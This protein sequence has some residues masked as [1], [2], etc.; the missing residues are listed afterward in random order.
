MGKKL[1]LDGFKL[2]RLDDSKPNIFKV[3]P[4]LCFF[5]KKKRFSLVK[6]GKT[7][8]K[9]DQKLLLFRFS[10][11][12]C[13]GIFYFHVQKFAFVFI[14]NRFIKIHPDLFSIKCYALF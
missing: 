4:L 1:E 11:N 12:G 6:F 9:I 13:S 3:Q 14:D 8:V 10:V 2:F 5:F 7:Y